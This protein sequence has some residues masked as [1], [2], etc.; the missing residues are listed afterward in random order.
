[1]VIVSTHVVLDITNG[2]RIDARPLLDRP[3]RGHDL[4]AAASS[5]PLAPPTRNQPRPT[6]GPRFVFEASPP[7]SETRTPVRRSSVK[8]EGRAKVTVA[9]VARRKI[10]ARGH[11]RLAS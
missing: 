10:G 11:P 4:F 2:E 9:A 1:M 7:P 5:C 6:L 3:K 8:S